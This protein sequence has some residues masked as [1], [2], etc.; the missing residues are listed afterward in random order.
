MYLTTWHTNIYQKL[1]EIKEET[2][3][4]TKSSGAQL[5]Q[6]KDQQTEFTR[7]KKKEGYKEYE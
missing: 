6:F 4:F 7:K 2:D 1:V 3:N 5:T